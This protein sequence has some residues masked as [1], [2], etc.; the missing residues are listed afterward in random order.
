[1]ARGPMDVWNEWAPQILVVLSFTLQLLL[2]LLAG[3]RQH[4][5]A[6]C[7]LTAVLKGVLWLAYQLADSTAIYAIGHLSLCDPPPEHQLVPFWAPFLL[8][9][10]GGPDNITA[11]SLEDTKLWL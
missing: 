5:G 7:L 4:R 6:S 11:Y 8:L 9:H 1:M 10:L 3:I 2:L